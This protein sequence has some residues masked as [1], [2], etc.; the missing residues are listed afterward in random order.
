MVIKRG[1]RREREVERMGAEI[2]YLGG[3]GM[4]KN[5]CSHSPFILFYFFE[6]INII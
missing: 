2:R 1:G 4:Q 6:Y 5:I 3:G